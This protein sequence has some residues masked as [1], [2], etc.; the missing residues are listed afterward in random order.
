MFQLIPQSDS[1][2]DNAKRM[3]THFADQP[4]SLSA[5][6]QEITE[7]H[8]DALIYPDIGMD[9]LTI[10]LASHRLAPLQAASW[11]HP[12][13]TGLPTMDLYISADAFEPQ[14]AAENYSERLLRLPNL[15]VYVEPLT[16]DV[17]D[18][19][20][21]ALK[22]PNNQPLLLC[23]GSPFKYVPLYDDVWVQIARQLRKRFFS[24]NSGGRLVFF[25]SRSDTMDQM[26]EGRLRTAFAKAEVDFDKHVSIIRTL[27]RAH[28]FGLM[29]RS[30]LLLDTLGFSGFN[31]ALQAIE[32]DL[33]VLA[34]EG[35]F[36]RGRLASAIMRRLDLPELVATTQ[37]EFILKAVELA[38]DAGK[39]STL[40]AKIIERRKIL[41][42]D[43]PPRARPRAS[44]G[45]R[46]HRGA[47]GVLLGLG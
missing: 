29:K 35:D 30:A 32:C 23:P 2:S 10:R 8:L 26:L 1:E 44:L 40:Q 24:R 31:T 17:T 43:E 25:R 42:H 18:P 21:H 41:F 6:V 14:N 46:N 3:V 33:P 28:F 47:C 13:T 34:Y 5:W 19:D 12:E 38:A 27:K 22:L 20:L 37:E 39:R 45:G 15:G 9:P 4:T 16:P 36:M 7:K 11:G